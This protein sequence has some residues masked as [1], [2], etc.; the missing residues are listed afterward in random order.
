MF[1]LYK[2]ELKKIFSQKYLI[3]VSI[4]M[5][6]FLIAVGITPYFTGSIPT[7]QDVEKVSGRYIDDSLIHEVKDS[8][9][10]GVYSTIVDFMKQSVNSNEIDDYYAADIYNKRLLTIEKD[11]QNSYLSKAE[12]DYWNKRAKEIETPF[13]YYVDTGYAEVYDLISFLCMCVLMIVNVATSGIFAGEKASGT[14]QIILCTKQGRG[15]LFGAKLLACITVG[16]IIPLAI[17][18]IIVLVELSVFGFGGSN[19]PLQVHFPTC[20]YKITIG[21][22]LLYC[23]ARLVPAGIMWS[24]LTLFLSEVTGKQQACLAISIA[25]IFFSMINVPE[26]F[27]LISRIWH[28]LPGAN[29][30]GPW[31]FGEYR[32][33]NLFGVLLNDFYASAFVWLI[34][35]TILIIISKKLYKRI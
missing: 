22:S 15:K 7:N 31:M 2:Y 11:M 8:N 30:A 19:T 29:N 18:G 21:E 16:M 26:S 23:L 35:S 12:T 5:T 14:D 17:F 27:G 6:L 10:K 32:M 20:L 13:V 9:G 24:C 3:L 33:I 4:V 28:Y 25:L 1:T 34:V